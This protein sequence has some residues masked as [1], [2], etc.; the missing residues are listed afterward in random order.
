MHENGTLELV[1]FLL[2]IAVFLCMMRLF[3]I[4]RT[5]NLADLENYATSF[6]FGGYAIKRWRGLMLEKIEAC[7]TAQEAARLWS[8]ANPGSV[9]EV[10]ADEK[11]EQLSYREVMAATSE[12]EFVQL[13]T[14]LHVTCYNLFVQR[15]KACS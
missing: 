3:A 2:A 13:A 12:R 11:W 9:V 10:R 7:T 5:D 6:P 8:S 14:H 4:W 15:R 1:V